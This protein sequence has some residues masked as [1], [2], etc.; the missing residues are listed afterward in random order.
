MSRTILIVGLSITGQSVLRYYQRKKQLA[1]VI[2]FDDGL[3]GEQLLELEKRFPEVVFIEDE[4]ALRNVN[5]LQLV[6][7]SPGVPPTK[8]FLE[9][10]RKRKI[11]I[12]GDVELFAREISQLGHA[13]I[14]AI[15]G[16]NGKSTVTHLTGEFLK[17]AGFKVVVAG[18][19]GLPVLD[20]LNELADYWVLE[21]SSFQLETLYSL[22][23]YRAA[24]L[25][26]S[27]DHLDRYEGFEDYKAA[28]HR[29]FQNAEGLIYNLDDP[30]TFPLLSQTVKH[31]TFSV[32]GQADCS[33][34]DKTLHI[35]SGNDSY[36]INTKD[37]ALQGI[38][39]F[40]NVLAASA[41]IID[42]KIPFSCYLKVLN[43]EEGLA[44]RCQVVKEIQGVNFINDS[45]GTNVG[46]SV[47]AIC[48]FYSPEKKL[49]LIAGGLAKGACLLPL[50][51]VSQEKV[52]F[53]VLIG[54]DKEAF[55]KVL[56]GHCDYKFG[57]SLEEAVM[58]AWQKAKP[59][60]TVLFSPGAASFD[61]FNNFSHRGDCFMKIVRELT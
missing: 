53:A 56:D 23:P 48:G 21:L 58:I 2:A 9:E 31:Y 50:E 45:K 10:I 18:N 54:K 29:I 26:I 5:S 42:E 51:Q 36:S 14:I 22:R 38:H 57:N 44:H 8:S 20:R 46:A 17:A 1:S 11:P 12:V 39:N 27:D 30:H 32:N 6:V 61:M 7:K 25:N 28:K 55:A 47:S 49:V 4:Q 37:V 15:T 43:K 35:R 59:F 41:L 16:T 24:L 34:A 3:S 19:I 40:A 13:K 33:Y 52:S 60:G